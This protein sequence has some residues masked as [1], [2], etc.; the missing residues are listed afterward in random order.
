[1]SIIRMMSGIPFFR[2]VGLPVLQQL[3][4]DI[5]IAHHW[6]PGLRIKLNSFRHKGYWFHRRNREYDS[7]QLFA[8]LIA[9]GSTV[10]E[11]GGH[12]GYITAHFASI[13]GPNGNVI[14]FEPG[15][16]NLP[17]M[18]QNI[19][20]VSNN[21]SLATVTLVEKAVGPTEGSV[22]FYE[23]DLTGQNNSIVKN[24][25][26]LRE[27]AKR[28]FINTTVQ[29][30]SVEMTSLDSYLINLHVDFIKI[31]VE[32]FE[33]GVIHGM[34]SIL[35]TQKPIIMVEVQSSEAE[36]YHF[37][38]SMGYVL[39]SSARLPIFNASQLK[40]NVFCF[41]C[42]KHKEQLNHLIAQKAQ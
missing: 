9:R 29:T 13:T 16:N 8:E 33:L 28:A 24:F 17:Y 31:D 18:R 32:G 19:I 10:V 2:R 35:S 39:I 3:N 12:I 23:D 20:N 1:M 15:S 36:I 26:G 6:V 11:V 25:P 27:N 41:H 4:F 40:N 21:K 42:E 30:R 7:M 34:R 22:T 14:V 37:L 38:K 5:S